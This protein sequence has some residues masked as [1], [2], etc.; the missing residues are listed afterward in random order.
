MCQMHPNSDIQL[1]NYFLTI[2][3][4]STHQKWM[5][6]AFIVTCSIFLQSYWVSDI[7]GC[8]WSGL[9]IFFQIL[10]NLLWYVLWYPLYY[11][12]IPVNCQLS[13]WGPCICNEA[14]KTRNVTIPAK[15]GGNCSQLIESCDLRPCRKY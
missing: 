6:F 3:S 11:I 8:L 12:L 1:W 5:K 7:V 2:N 14:I 9:S 4:D 13:D 15:N 10:L